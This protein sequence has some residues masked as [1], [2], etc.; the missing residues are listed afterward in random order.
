[1][2][3]SRHTMLARTYDKYKYYLY[4]SHARIAYLFSK[5]HSKLYYYI[6]IQKKPAGMACITQQTL[7][8]MAYLENHTS[9]LLGVFFI[10]TGVKN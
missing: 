3:G 7:A 4:T 1:M 5:F 9:V 8:R 2:F 10:V 6:K